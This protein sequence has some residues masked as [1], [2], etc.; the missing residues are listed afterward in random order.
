MTHLS[1]HCHGGQLV[2]MTLQ[3]QERRIW[4][5]TAAGRELQ[6]GNLSSVIPRFLDL[7]ALFDIFPPF[8]F[9]LSFHFS[10][11]P[12]TCFHWANL[13]QDVK[14][15]HSVAEAWLL[16]LCPSFL[17]IC[18]LR[19]RGD[20]EMG[21]IR[22]GYLIFSLL[23][24]LLV[25]R[26]DVKSENTCCDVAVVFFYPL[27]FCLTLKSETTPWWSFRTFGKAG[28]SQTF[29]LPKAN[30]L[31]QLPLVLEAI[32]KRRRCIT[33]NNVSSFPCCRVTLFNPH[34]SKHLSFPGPPSLL[35]PLPPHPLRS[36]APFFFSS[37]F[38]LFNT[39]AK[40]V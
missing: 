12:R 26:Y 37:S 32:C 21:R 4:P 9:P 35:I 27:P 19:L 23:F 14:R 1:S 10:F 30:L 24:H 22:K 11:S 7:P 25:L 34:Y 13:S 5:F 33:R 31:H 38:H 16:T 6:T 8:F 2:A 20:S 18:W 28:N 36:V 17:P 15:I 3:W 39:N 40:E 29:T